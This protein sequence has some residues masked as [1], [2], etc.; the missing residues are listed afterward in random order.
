[1]NNDNTRKQVLTNEK[2]N[3]GYVDASQHL[4]NQPKPIEQP[5]EQPPQKPQ[6]E[7]NA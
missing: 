3:K 6:E 7:P 2:D 5:A 4:D 1:M